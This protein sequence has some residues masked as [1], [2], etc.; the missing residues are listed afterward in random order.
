M[1]PRAGLL[2]PTDDEIHPGNSQNAKSP[3]IRSTQV[4][5]ALVLWWKLSCRP[6]A[7]PNSQTPD[8][9]P[10]TARLQPVPIYNKYV[11]AFSKHYSTGE[12]SLVFLNGV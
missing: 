12:G 3:Y 4:M 6:V 11:V 2:C 7:L 9:S 10:K 5:Y 1:H 8:I